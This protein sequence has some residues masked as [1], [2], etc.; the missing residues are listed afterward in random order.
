MMARTK[1]GDGPS[2]MSLVRDAIEKLG[3]NAKPKVMHDYILETH[4]AD[5]PTGMISS[6]KS[7]L[8]KKKGTGKKRGRK[9]N[10]EKGLPTKAA[11]SS[12]SVTMSDIAEVKIL[13]SRHGAKKLSDLI[14]ALS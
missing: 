12:A 5:I 7:M 6:Y 14:G 2:K 10:A 11:T 9:S 1:A 4:K 13:L 8:S 3:K